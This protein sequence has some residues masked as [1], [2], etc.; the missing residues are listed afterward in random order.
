MGTRPSQ[1][2]VVVLRKVLS[3]LEEA[4]DPDDTALAHLK[5]ILL[6]RIAEIETAR[7]QR[8]LEVAAQPPRLGEEAFFST[9]IFSLPARVWSLR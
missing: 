9:K 6:R 8:V 3:D 2:L 1:H 7:S 5:T 4:T